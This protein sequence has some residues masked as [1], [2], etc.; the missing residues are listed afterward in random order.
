M[1]NYAMG[2]AA[3]NYDGMKLEDLE[4]HIIESTGVSKSLLIEVRNNNIIIN[5]LKQ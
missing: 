1:C 3:F 4:D 5:K 2:Y